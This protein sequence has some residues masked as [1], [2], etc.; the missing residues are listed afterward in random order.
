MDFAFKLFVFSS[1]II[2]CA[3]GKVKII[4]FISKFKITLKLKMF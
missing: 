2:N 4:N 1:E 3:G